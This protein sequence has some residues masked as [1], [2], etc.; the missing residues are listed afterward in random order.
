[1]YSN[2]DDKNKV[3]L[4]FLI[5]IRY[6]MGYFEDLFQVNRFFGNLFVGVNDINNIIYSNVCF[7]NIC[8]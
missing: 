7:S 6:Y 1:M 8:G 2:F 3:F 4:I 5:D